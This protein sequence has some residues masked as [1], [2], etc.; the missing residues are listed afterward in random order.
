[1][2]QSYFV[3]LVVASEFRPRRRLCC[4]SRSGDLDDVVHLI[5]VHYVFEEIVD[6]HFCAAVYDG[7]DLRPTVLQTQG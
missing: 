5:F 1:M 4:P 3:V 2:N 6:V 7:V